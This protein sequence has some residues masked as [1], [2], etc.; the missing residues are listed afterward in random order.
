[1]GKAGYLE[2]ITND[3]PQFGSGGATQA[4]TRQPIVVNKIIDTRTGK[5]L[6]E[7]GQ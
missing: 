1:M 6:Y 5:V 7:R 3:F 4:V 2:P